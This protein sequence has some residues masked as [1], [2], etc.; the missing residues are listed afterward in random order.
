MSNTETKAGGLSDFVASQIRTYVPLVVAAVVGWLAGL[1]VDLD[2]SAQEAVGSL[3]GFAAGLVWYFGVRLL[4][5]RWPQL[6][7]LLGYPAQP[8][9][10]GKHTA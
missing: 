8:K 1:G 4:E 6:G 2:P 10:T 3:L 9:Y 5:R 7:W